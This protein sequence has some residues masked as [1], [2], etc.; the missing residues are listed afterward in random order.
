MASIISSS[1]HLLKRPGDR[2]HQF[3]ELFWLKQR[4]DYDGLYNTLLD[5]R[6]VFEP[7]GLEPPNSGTVSLEETCIR[8]RQLFNTV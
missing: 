4:P 2:T 1:P 6:L 8:Y 3:F 5:S 7:P